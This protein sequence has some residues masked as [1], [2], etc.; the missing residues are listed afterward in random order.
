MTQW[1]P[2]APP[3]KDFK[4]PA[5]D[6]AKPFVRQQ[7]VENSLWYMGGL[8]TIYATSQ[9]TGGHFTFFEGNSPIGFSPP[10]HIHETEH[11]ALFVAEGHIIAHCGDVVLD[12]PRNS[13]VFL[14]QGIVHW[15]ET[16]E[17]ARLMSIASPGGADMKLFKRLGEPATALVMPPPP[18]LSKMNLK[19]V[20]ELGREVNVRFPEFEK[21][22]GAGSDAAPTGEG[23]DRV[24]LQDGKDPTKHDR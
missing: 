21:L 13:F 6:R 3:E 1:N 14:P 23:P 12:A 22:L 11:E 20:L 24:W 18:D 4:N 19:D 2:N 15:F 9:E 16:V 10:P 8:F 5:F 17:Q 7:T